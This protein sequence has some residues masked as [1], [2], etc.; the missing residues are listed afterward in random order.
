M[1]SFKHLVVQQKTKIDMVNKPIGV[2]TTI[3]IM[4][5]TIFVGSPKIKV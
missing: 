5:Y 2:S 1:P 4:V 3:I